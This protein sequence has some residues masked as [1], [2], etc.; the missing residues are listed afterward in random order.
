MN[1]KQEFVLVGIA[2]DK[3]PSFIT[4]S[5]LILKNN[6]QSTYI[7]YPKYLYVTVMSTFMYQPVKCNMY[8]HQAAKLCTLHYE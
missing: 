4:Y 6:S 7:T 5:Y 1:I 3:R 8:F 2:L